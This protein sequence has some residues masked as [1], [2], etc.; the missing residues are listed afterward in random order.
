MFSFFSQN[1]DGLLFFLGDCFLLCSLKSP[2][3]VKSEKFGR[4]VAKSFST[5]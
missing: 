3:L 2:P 1:L 5:C 4:S